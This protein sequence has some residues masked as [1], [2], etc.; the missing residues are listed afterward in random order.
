MRGH[1]SIALKA[2]GA[3]AK[4]AFGRHR[5]IRKITPGKFGGRWIRARMTRLMLKTAHGEVTHD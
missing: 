3:G 1:I 2:T 5:K 4:W